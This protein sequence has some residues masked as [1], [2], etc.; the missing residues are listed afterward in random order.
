[1]IFL[2]NAV[3]DLLLFGIS[4]LTVGILG[5]GIRI[6]LVKLNAPFKEQ[7]EAYLHRVRSRLHN[8]KLT[9]GHG[10]QLIGSHQRSLDHLQRCR[11]IVLSS[12]DRSRHDE[13]TVSTAE[14]VLHRFGIALVIIFA[15]EVNGIAAFLFVLVKP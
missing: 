5:Y 10:F 13:R 15:D 12:A 4:H 8:N 1:M 3:D 7:L 11:G 14:K 9:F 6:V 2:H